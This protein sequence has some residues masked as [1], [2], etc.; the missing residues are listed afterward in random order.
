MMVE[1]PFPSP[2]EL[3]DIAPS[4]G[5][6]VALAQGE[7]VR[8]LKIALPP[9]VT[10]FNAREGRTG[11]NA[12]RVPEEKDFSAAPKALTNDH[13]GKVM[14]ATPDVRT[15]DQGVGTFQKQ[16]PVVVFWIEGRLMSEEMDEQQKE[17]AEL[18]QLALR[19]Y[20]TGCADAQNRR[21]WRQLIPTGHSSVP[22]DWK[23]FSGRRC[24][25]TMV[26]SPNMDVD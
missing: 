24:D 23:E 21:V 18:I 1:T 12:L 8:R 5:G 14:V 2:S 26:Q 7:I 20:L 19:P 25:Y 17:F 9:L 10:A 15:R 6:R 4:L 3:L 11:N 13:I 22:G 16:V